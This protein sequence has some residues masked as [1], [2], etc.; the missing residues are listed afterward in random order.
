MERMRAGLSWLLLLA[1]QFGVSGAFAAQPAPAATTQ[2]AARA[3]TVT[4][5]KLANGLRVVLE[6]DHRLPIVG[7]T[8][9]YELGADPTG[10]PL[11]VP[12]M[13]IRQSGHLAVGDYQRLL[14]EAGGGQ[15]NWSVD[16]DRTRFSLVVPSEQV[17]LPLWL[18]SDQMGFF[19]SQLD[20]NQVAQGERTL[21]VERNRVI[22]STRYGA[23]REAVRAAL[24]PIGHPYQAAPIERLVVK[25]TVTS[26]RNMVEQSYVPNLA[27]VSLVGD[28]ESSAALA[29]IERYF[30]AFKEVAPTPPRSVMLTDHAFETNLDLAANVDQELVS[31]VYRL[32]KEANIEA[33][34]VLEY[35]LGN[36]SGSAVYWSLEDFVT[37]ADVGLAE[38][39]LASEFRVELKIR[40][41]RS[42]KDALAALK[43]ALRNPMAFSDLTLRGAILRVS[44]NEAL[45]KESF[46]WRAVLN[47]RRPEDKGVRKPATL[48]EARSALASLQQMPRVVAMVRRDPNASIAGDLRAVRRIERVDAQ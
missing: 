18:W 22:T 24:Y 10:F 9:R 6:E 21:A 4:E 8:M 32:P 43:T 37:S 36:V 27:T 46:F 28:F 35:A 23:V 47:A 33:F 7:A 48:E 19:S 29:S 30:G 34:R 45:N 38:Y 26:L 39:H 40:A 41:D 14:A 15:L 16:L 42:G 17:S 12:G 20:A 11:I 1:L 25:P 5:T 44:M 3:G 2:T 31:V 13:M